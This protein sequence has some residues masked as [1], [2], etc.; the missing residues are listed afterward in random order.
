M[1][2]LYHNR[3]PTNTETFGATYCADIKDLLQQSDFV[4]LS[5]PYTPDTRHIINSKTL[6]HMKKSA[7]L[8]NVAR[9]GVVDQDALVQALNSGAIAGAGLDVTEP[10]PL[11][12]DHPLLTAKNV[13]ILPHFGSATTRTRKRMFDLTLSNLIAG[14][15]G[16]LLPASVPETVGLKGKRTEKE[17]T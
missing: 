9:G 14:L 10:E 13:L 5:L 1:R 3:K 15:E 16:N 7:F 2:V 12:R 4:V 8:I 6:A 17:G 11:P